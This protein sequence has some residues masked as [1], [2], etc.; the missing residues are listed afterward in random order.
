MLVTV[1]VDSHVQDLAV[2]LVEATDIHISAASEP[3]RHYTAQ[4]A[5]RV[6]QQGLRGGD[7]RRAAVRRLLRAGGYRP[8]GRNKPAQ[9]Y[10]LRT[11]GE[12]PTLPSIWNAVDL[13]NAVSLDSGLPISLVAVERTGPRL[14]VRYGREGESYVFNRAGQDLDLAGLICLCAGD[15]E[16]AAPAATPVKDSLLAKVTEHDRRVLACIYA[17]RSGISHEELSGWNQQLGEGFVRWCGASSF[18]SRLDPDTW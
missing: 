9:E 2:G 11:I 7:E 13:I 1:T 3:L 16:R 5:E 6:R 14:V 17:P 10:L 15:P 4:V 18:A 8:A 12:E